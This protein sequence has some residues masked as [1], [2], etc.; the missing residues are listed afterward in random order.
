EKTT[1][2]GPRTKDK[3]TMRQFAGRLMLV[4]TIFAGAS[5]QAAENTESARQE[6]VKK[7]INY[8]K[9]SQADDGSWT[10]PK[11]IGITGLVVNALIESGVPNDD[12]A[13]QNGL[14]Y[15]ESFVQ[16]DGGIYVPKNTHRNY[17]T[18]IALMTFAAADKEKY[19]PVI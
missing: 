7:G 11:T 19:Q 5:L 18:C 13:V 6:A 12:P 16:D 9:S 10:T 1:D 4:A 15:L 3:F 8:L 2:N 17:E 14:K